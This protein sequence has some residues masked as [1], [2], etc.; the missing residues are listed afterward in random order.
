MKQKIKG[1]EIFQLTDR[2]TDRQTDT[3][4]GRS[5]NEVYSSK[6]FHE[7]GNKNRE[8]KIRKIT[9]LQFTVIFYAMFGI[10]VNGNIKGRQQTLVH[11][12]SSRVKKP[13]I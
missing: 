4:E 11:L 2:Q 5:L 1:T 12:T 9:L 7:S 10:E 13:G 3:L 8:N 6:D